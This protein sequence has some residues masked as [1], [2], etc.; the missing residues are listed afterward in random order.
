MAPLRQKRLH[1]QGYNYIV[2]LPDKGMDTYI[3]RNTLNGKF[4]IGSAKNFEIRKKEHL[5]S[6]E[7][8]PFQNALRNNPEA[9]EWEVHTDESEDRE[10]EQA[11]LD[12]FFGT[13]MC[14]N[15]NPKASAPP[16]LYGVDNPR[17][18]LAPE[19]NP[20]YGKK[21]WVNFDGSEEKFQIDNPGENWSEGRKIVS[22]ETKNKQSQRLT[23]K[24]WWVNPDG[25]MVK[26]EECPGPGWVRGMNDKFKQTCSRTNQGPGNPSF[27][28]KWWVNAEGQTRYQ[29][30]SPGPEWQNGRVYRPDV[31]V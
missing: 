30:T 10:L 26:Q 25:E 27:G 28:K 11:L 6:K 4:Y 21:W 24:V 5:A 13:E 20:H 31:R 7:N 2:I 22:E 9:F 12:M 14:Y 15:L 18:G 19:E 17:F 23:G 3:S 8:Y 16:V 1:E 29:E